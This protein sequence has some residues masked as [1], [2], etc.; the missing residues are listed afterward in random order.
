MTVGVPDVLTG[1]T[2]YDGLVRFAEGLRIVPSLAKRWEIGAD[3]LTYTFHLVTA[4]W[5][6]GQP[7]TSDDV[8]YTLLEVSSK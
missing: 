7:L 2:L 8:K 3:G 4:N 1:C 6:D 5:S